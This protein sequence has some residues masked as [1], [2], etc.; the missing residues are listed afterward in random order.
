MTQPP[1]ALHQIS[2]SYSVEGD[3]LLMR[4]STSDKNEFHFLLTR[5]FVKVLWPA[6][7]TVIDQ[8]DATT[9][10]SLMPAARK[11][12]T[13]MQ[14]LEAV[15]AADFTQP[16][17]DDTKTLTKEP[18]LVIGG[19]VH[20]GKKGLTGITLKTKDKRQGAV[21][22]ATGKQTGAEIKISLNKNLLHAL[23]RLLIETTMKAGWD[24]GIAVGAAAGM[25]RQGSV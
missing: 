12:V 2:M 25:R 5:R 6:L 18:L 15:K 1:G 17:D 13:A 8:E 23:C 14:H 4:V 19:S 3:R 20:P 9:K 11:A 7:M 22:A 24:L 21:T 16:H 10:Q